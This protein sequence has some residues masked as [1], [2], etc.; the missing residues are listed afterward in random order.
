[1]AFIRGLPAPVVVDPTGPQ[2]TEDMRAGRRL[3]AEVGCATCHTPTLGDVKGIYS[4]LLLH[5]MGQSLSDSGSS[6]GIDGPSSPVGP[7]PREWRTPPLWG[8]RDSGPYLHDGRAQDLEEAVAL[9]DGQAR[10]SA[11]RF[12]GLNSQERAQVEVF[13]KSLVAPSAA[14]APGIAL[15]AEM[16]SGPSRTSGVH[17]RRSC[18][19]G[20][21]GRWPATSSSSARP[22]SAGEPRR[23]RSAPGPDPAGP[24]P[25]ADGQ[26][27]RCHRL[28]P[29]DRPGCLRHGR[30]P[31]GR[32]EGLGTEHA[33]GLAST[34]GI[35]ADGAVVSSPGSVQWTSAWRPSSARTMAFFL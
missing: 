32:R 6:Y 24:V 20:A 33:E 10:A 17:L 1:M 11:H 29:G 19:A 35:R 3:F 25:R 16:E 27:H 21:S 26:D 34:E 13:L 28:L 18:D 30:R 22:R 9:H 8:Y 2:G 14:A 15:A 12:F 7:S 4:D 31:A 23:P 5:D